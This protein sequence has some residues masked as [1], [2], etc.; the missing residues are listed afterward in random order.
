MGFPGGSLVKNLP[1][2]SGSARDVCLIPEHED[3]L[4]KEV[5]THSSI[6]ALPGKSHR[7]RS[8]EGYSPWNRQESD[9]TERLGTQANS[10]YDFSM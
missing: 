7:Q 10:K 5:A 3:P 6:L 2:N 8:L 1:A 4:E 9:M